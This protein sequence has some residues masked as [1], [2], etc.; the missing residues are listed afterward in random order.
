MIFFGKKLWVS[1]LYPHH[2]LRTLKMGQV[3]S[4]W[5]RT[6]RTTI[7]V[8][9]TRS[10]LLDLSSCACCWVS[11]QDA[12]WEDEHLFR[13][14]S[15]LP[16]IWEEGCVDF[17]KGVGTSP[18]WQPIESMP[19]GDDDL[20]ALLPSNIHARPYL[21]VEVRA[22]HRSDGTCHRRRT[23][24]ARLQQWIVAA[25]DLLRGAH[26]CADMEGVSI[27]GPTGQ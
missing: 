14:T 9:R 8:A 26:P 24:D 19:V 16:H 12:G 25:A 22:S 2:G 4:P 15:T 21:A 18:S 6:S 3:H 13:V 7:P 11:A 10:H 27:D 20:V 17:Q 1:K 5:H 23:W